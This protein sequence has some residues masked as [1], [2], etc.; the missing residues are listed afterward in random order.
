MCIR[1]IGLKRESLTVVLHCLFQPAAFFQ[2]TGESC[3]SPR[4]IRLQLSD[5]R[6]AT[7]RQLGFTAL[8]EGHTQIGQRLGKIG[9]PYRRTLKAADR[10]I[11]VASCKESIAQIVL[12]LGRCWKLLGHT[13]VFCNFLIHRVYPYSGNSSVAACL[14]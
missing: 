4:V 11:E 10:L 1:K 8:L 3:L 14:P 13:A 2:G 7:D 12:R 6:K 5:A 9:S